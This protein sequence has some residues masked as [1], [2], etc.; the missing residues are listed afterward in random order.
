MNREWKRISKRIFSL[1]LATT[2]VSQGISIPALAQTVD[3]TYQTGTYIGEA[4]G[5]NDI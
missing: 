3:N 2:V 4:I 1:I 5:Y